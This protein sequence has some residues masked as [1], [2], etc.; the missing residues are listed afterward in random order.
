VNSE[1]WAVEW[2][3]R[4]SLDGDQRYLVWD[5]APQMWR[6]RRECRAE[7]EARY[8]YI[9]QRPD[10]RAEPHG[11]FLPRAVRVSVRTQKEES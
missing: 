2:H 9:R 10:L 4:N 5:G 8:G 3:S 1:F 6:T 7:I 11:W